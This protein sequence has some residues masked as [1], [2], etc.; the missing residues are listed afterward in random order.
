MSHIID[1][2][3][4]VEA[5]EPDRPFW[6]EFL[7]RRRPRSLRGGM[8]AGLLGG[9]VIGAI[10]CTS[11]CCIQL[12]GLP[13]LFVPGLSVAYLI[14]AAVR[15]FSGGTDR[16]FGFVAAALALLACL[17]LDIDLAWGI[18]VS[19]TGSSPRFSPALA[20]SLFRQHWEASHL[21]S[22][23]LAAGV[24][25]YFG[26]ERSQPTSQP[27]RGTHP[28]TLPLGLFVFFILIGG[29]VLFSLSGRRFNRLSLSPDGHMLVADGKGDVFRTELVCWDLPSGRQLGPRDHF[30][31]PLDQ[32]QGPEFLMGEGH[33]GPIRCRIRSPASRTL[34][35]AEVKDNRVKGWDALT[36]RQTHCFELP[37][38]W[39]P[40]SP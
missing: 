26:W 9:L 19:Q 31:K 38:A 25:Y 10:F 12:S 3:P 1:T 21:L 8:V 35:A 24:A 22:Y 16:R 7:R 29:L 17:V 18:M 33:S 13:L 5:S 32:Q 20:L 40:A 30:H 14:G 4:S 6:L 27:K 23:G 39:I 36:G 28:W 11:W 37:L 2:M 15:E 34:F